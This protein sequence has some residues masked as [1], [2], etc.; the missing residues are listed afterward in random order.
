TEHWRLRACAPS[1]AGTTLQPATAASTSASWVTGRALGNPKPREASA[2]DRAGGDAGDR[3]SRRNVSGDDGAC[4]DQGS[5]PY[6]H[7][8]EDTRVGADRRTV[9]HNRQLERPVVVSLHVTLVVG[10][11]RVAVIVEHHP[12]ADEDLIADLDAAADEAVALDLAARADDRALL[13]LDERPDSRFVS[14]PAAVQV[15]ERV[16][17]HAFAELDIGDQ[18]KRRVVDRRVRNRRSTP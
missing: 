17:D 12:V 4:A 11:A 16:D 10:S 5:F 9:A 15:R 3:F 8:A 2:L 18:A 1:T 14:D 7:T 6:R 13:D